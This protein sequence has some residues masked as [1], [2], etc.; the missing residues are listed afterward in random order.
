MATKNSINMEISNL[1]IRKLLDQRYPFLLVDKIL[2]I[3]KNIVWGLKNVSACDPF[4]AGHFPDSPVYPGVLLIETCAQVGGALFL[5]DIDKSHN[6]YLANIKDFKFLGFIV[7]GDTII[8]EAKLVHEIASF[9]NIDVIA[10]VDDKI[11][12]KGSIVY[13]FLKSLK[14]KS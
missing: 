12:G 8:V 13:S 5:N 1:E 7:P 10:R 14:R 6:G 4:L 3:E 2:K 11:V 9:A